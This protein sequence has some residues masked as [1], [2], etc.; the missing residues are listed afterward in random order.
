MRDKSRQTHIIF[1]TD[2]SLNKRFNQSIQSF[3]YCYRRYTV[4]RFEVIG[5]NS[6]NTPESMCDI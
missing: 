2:V 1:D 6:F 4:R 5:E 3:G